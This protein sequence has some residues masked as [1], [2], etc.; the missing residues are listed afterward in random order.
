MR[1]VS[2]AAAC[3][4]LAA[5][6]LA[7]PVF[8]DGV[9]AIAGGV[10]AQQRGAPAP[11]ADDRS[12]AQRLGR[13]AAARL[14]HD[15]AAAML[16][17]QV[18]E[19][20]RRRAQ[21]LRG[22]PRS[23]GGVRDGPRQN[24]AASFCWRVPSR[25]HRVQ[26]FLAFSTPAPRASQDAANGW[27]HLPATDA[28]RRSKPGARANG[29]ELRR[30]PLPAARGGL[31][32]R[33]ACSRGR[34][35]RLRITTAPRR[36]GRRPPAPALAR[37]LR[38]ILRGG[39]RA[40]HVA[41]RNRG[42]RGGARAQSSQFI[43][44]PG[45]FVEVQGVVAV[46]CFVQ[47]RFRVVPRGGV[48]RRPTGA[49]RRERISQAWRSQGGGACAAPA[50]YRGICRHLWRRAARWPRPTRGAVR[51]RAVDF[52]NSTASQKAS[53]AVM[54]DAK[55]LAAVFGA[56]RSGVASES[57][58]AQALRVT[59]SSF[60]SPRRAQISHASHA[61]PSAPLPKRRSGREGG[62]RRVALGLFL[63]ARAFP[64]R[65]PAGTSVAA[66]DQRA[67]RTSAPRR[68]GAFPRAKQTRPAREGTRPPREGSPS[69]TAPPRGRRLAR[70]APRALDGARCRAAL[71]RYL[72]IIVSVIPYLGSA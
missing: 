68:H 61:L 53:W 60:G 8:P 31:L 37:N 26:R 57:L 52:L 65:H 17:E 13:A 18:D 47:A 41:R 56:S 16:Q 4:A 71:Q 9:E 43:H 28:A 49:R 25:R 10:A 12:A 29:A 34:A 36:S 70:A 54:C 66:A 20:R 15:L 69:A 32:V 42:A 14:E 2:H 48:A 35:L 44:G 22:Q 24:F 3:A 11:G 67:G 19:D 45:I 33:A 21:G 23:G 64:A 58:L 5:A 72:Y 63:P 7:Q 62:R 46:R 39:G 51:S 30:A 40:R 27:R 59:G 1:A 38:R 50:E 55:W 6:A